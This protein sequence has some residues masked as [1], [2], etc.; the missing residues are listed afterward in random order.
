MARQ[1]KSATRVSDQITGPGSASTGSPAATDDGDAQRLTPSGVPRRSVAPRQPFLVKLFAGRVVVLLALAVGCWFGNGQWQRGVSAAFVVSAILQPVIGRTVKRMAALRATMR[2]HDIIMAGLIPIAVSSFYWPLA[3]GFVAIL[4]IHSI[5]SP[6]SR[7]VPIALLVPIELAIVGAVTRIERFELVVGWTAFLAIVLGLVGRHLRRSTESTRRDL[8]LA[9]DAADAL[10]H[11]TKLGEGLVTMS[12]DVEK[13]IGWPRREWMTMEQFKVV[14]PDDHHIFRVDESQLVD[15]QVVDRTGRFR[16]KD[17]RWIWIRDVSRVVDAGSHVEL[18]G[19]TMNVTAQQVGLERV[20]EEATTDPLTGLKNRRAL[21]VELDELDQHVGH[22]LVLIDLNRFKEVNDTLGH[23]AG[24]ALLRVV[25]DRI[26]ALLPDH[27]FLAR[28]GGDEFAIIHREAVDTDVVVADVH[29]LS[30]ALMRPVEIS[31]VNVTT[32]I[33]AGVV[34][35]KPSQADQSTMLRHADMAMY[36]AKRNCVTTVVFDDEMGSQLEQ[37]LTLS[38]QVAQALESAEIVLHY[39]PIVDAQSGKITGVEGLARWEH[40]RQG[41]LPP[42]AFLDV[43]LLSERSGQFTECMVGQA[44]DAAAYFAAIGYPIPVSVNIPV[45]SV[46]DAHF[47]QWLADSCAEAGVPPSRIVLEVAERDLHDAVATMEAIDRLA[48]LGVGIAVDDFGTGHATFDRLRWRN[49]SQIKLDRDIIR[50]SA[51]DDRDCVI[52]RSIIDL[53]HALGYEVVAEGVDCA[54]QVAVL[55]AV[56]CDQ[57]QGYLFSPP[58]PR[59]GFVELLSH[60]V[61]GPLARPSLV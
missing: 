56:G 33:S 60:R 19:F 21:M 15:G 7:F 23:E 26:S 9:I 4:A 37:R 44:I 38:T 5:V 43:I 12:G 51:T 20:N 57:I 50:H 14:H 31:G 27:M 46:E 11:V 30:V 39:Q 35:A 28:L 8:H 40:P 24:D 10:T 29:T 34:R 59:D 41:V 36:A 1:Q 52:V 6:A 18:H 42:A 13:V 17:G 3:A 32:S 45:R 47:E 16:T 2:T 25:A 54:E 53:A 22:H 49:V 55:R 48:E 58:V 61:I